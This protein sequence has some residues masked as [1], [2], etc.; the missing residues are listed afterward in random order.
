MTHHSHDCQ[1]R[2]T[3]KD[4]IHFRRYS[5]FRIDDFE[6]EK[7]ILQYV[8]SYLMGLYVAQISKTKK[9]KKKLNKMFSTS[10]L[11]FWIWIHYV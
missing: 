8:S 1:E 11:K 4:I 9:V 2:P 10:Y 5:R 3:C 6:C 7:E